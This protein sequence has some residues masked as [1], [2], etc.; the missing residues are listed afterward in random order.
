[1][2]VN[3][4]HPTAQMA[5]KAFPEYTGRKFRYE[6][7]N[8]SMDLV[9]YWSGGSCNYYKIIDLTNDRILEI[10]QNGSGFE[11]I[12]PLNNIQAPAPGFV[13]VKHSIFCGKDCGLTI[14]IH[15][16]NVNPELIDEPKIELSNDELIVLLSISMFKNSYAGE[17]N[18][19]IKMAVRETKINPQKYIDTL[20]SLQRRGFISKSGGLTKLGKN[21]CSDTKIHS[22]SQ[23]KVNKD[24][25]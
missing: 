21:V 23:L 8:K 22:L 4:T 19:R 10:P 11:R 6:I 1:M 17:K 20:K 9:S 18:I 13:V 3:K 25:D 2:L 14:Y 16:E 7:C 5:I 24:N 15:P 12:K